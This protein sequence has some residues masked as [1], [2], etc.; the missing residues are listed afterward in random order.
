MISGK[1]RDILY[2]DPIGPQ[3]GDF[4]PP[5]RLKVIFLCGTASG[6]KHILTVIEKHRLIKTYAFNNLRTLDFS[7]YAAHEIVPQST[8]GIG[9]WHR[10][11][12]LRSCRSRISPP[13]R[14]SPKKSMGSKAAVMYSTAL[15]YPALIDLLYHGILICKEKNEKT[16]EFLEQI[17]LHG[18]PGSLYR[19]VRATRKPI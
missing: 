6:K 2:L 4:P 16:A 1:L 3:E 9:C 15:P 7:L 18:L 17:R 14:P 19:T 5:Q 10:N 8:G 11:R 13:C 12:F